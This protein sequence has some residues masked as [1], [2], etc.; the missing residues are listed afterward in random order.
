MEETMIYFDTDSTFFDTFV[1]IE[2]LYKI[3]DKE[4]NIK[5]VDEEYLK[6]EGL[7]KEI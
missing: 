5:Y 6:K 3:T 1:D 2:G 7:W 4:G